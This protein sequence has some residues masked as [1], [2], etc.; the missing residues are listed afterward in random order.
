MYLLR[1]TVATLKNH[2]W[3]MERTWT[4]ALGG[5][6]ALLAIVA[7]FSLHLV[8][9]AHQF[10]EGKSAKVSRGGEYSGRRLHCWVIWLPPLCPAV[11]EGGGGHSMA[12][13]SPPLWLAQ[14][15]CT[16]AHWASLL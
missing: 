6:E 4:N 15:G 7:G 10:A 3:P 16:G 12:F 5:A 13:S 14:E 2:H 9:S 1:M 8:Q 11:A